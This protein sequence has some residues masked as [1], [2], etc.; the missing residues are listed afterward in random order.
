MKIMIFA[1]LAMAFL[2]T[3]CSQTWDSFKSDTKKNWKSTKKSI[4]KATE[5]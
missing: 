3:G 1:I 2:S 4:N 5:E